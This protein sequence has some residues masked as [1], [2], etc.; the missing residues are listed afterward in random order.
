MPKSE[1]TKQKQPT[2]SLV[3]NSRLLL[4]L[5]RLNTKVFIQFLDGS[6]IFIA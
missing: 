5:L 4:F 6:T 2:I 3:R 1:R